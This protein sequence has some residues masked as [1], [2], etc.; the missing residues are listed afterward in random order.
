MVVRTMSALTLFHWGISASAYISTEAPAASAIRAETK[1]HRQPK[2]AQADEHAERL[3]GNPAGDLGPDP[4][5]DQEACREREHEFPPHVA[6]HREADR[7]QGVRHPGH[8]VL[9]RVDP[10]QRLTDHGAE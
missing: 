8:R 4:P 9:D 10:D 1:F 5:A 6:E 2:P 3:R 7:G